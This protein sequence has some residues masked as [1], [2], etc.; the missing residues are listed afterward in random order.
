MYRSKTEV[1]LLKLTAPVQNIQLDLSD[2]PEFDQ[3][4]WVSYWYPL[5]Q[6][7]NFK[8]DVYRKAMIE[9][10]QQLPQQNL[11]K[12]RACADFCSAIVI[13]KLNYR[14][15]KKYGAAPMSNMQLDT[16]RRIVQEINASTSL[17]ESLDIMVNQVAEAMHV[18]VCSI[19]LLD[20][21][22]QRYLLMASKGLKPE[23][24]GHVSLHTGE[25][26]VGLVGQ[27][28][29]IVNL[30]N[31]PKHDRFLYLPETGE[32]IYNSFLGVPVMYRRKVMGVLVVQNKES[33]DFSEAA[34]SFL[35]TLCAQLSGVIAHAHAVGNIDVFRKPNN[36]P[37]YKT[38]QGVSGSGGI[39]LG[40]A[41][42][43][44]PPADLGAVPD[45][46][47]DD[48]SEELALLDNALNSVREEIQFLDD[49]MQ[50]ALMAEE[51]ALFSVF[52]RMLDENALPS[53]IKALIRDGHWA[54][55]AVRIV[56]DNHVAQ[57]VQME[58]DYLRERVADLKIWD[59]VFW[60]SCR[61]PMKAIAN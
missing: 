45:R 42:V 32:E 31:A 5:G 36:L 7:V 37:A 19:Y 8:R 50:D 25:G 47:A 55:G 30:D 54:Q 1:V 4:Q 20:E 34:E 46:E 9:L 53:E 33:Q 52:L 48:I 22:N 38:F 28:E 56:I 61:K 3:W 60:P 21:R 16:L 14:T 57:F 49:K 6:V 27:R 29:E 17:H 44:Y 40:R 13:N 41:I 24:V 39:A 35:V 15:S 10:C 26:L 11:K 23:A 43:L 51:R 2:P 18:D 59:V 58:D 12:S